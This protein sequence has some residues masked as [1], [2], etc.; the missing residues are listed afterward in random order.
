M[1]QIQTRESNLIFQIRFIHFSISMHKYSKIPVLTI[2]HYFFFP[3]TNHGF[4]YG[5]AF[6]RVGRLEEKRC[7]AMRWT[8]D[9]SCAHIYKKYIRKQQLG[10]KKYAININFHK[11]PSYDEETKD[12]KMFYEILF[13]FFFFYPDVVYYYAFGKSL[14]EINVR[15]FINFCCKFT[16][17]QRK[18]NLLGSLYGL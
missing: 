12:R 4:V 3:W 17:N 18:T 10:E 9:V 7:D 14:T 13:C 6:Y 8:R 1:H 5:N 15:F 16:V 2:F 11:F